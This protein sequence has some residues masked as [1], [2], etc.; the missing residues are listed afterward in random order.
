ML[1]EDADVLLNGARLSPPAT[2]TDN[3]FARYDKFRAGEYCP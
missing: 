1:K 3:Y 2:F